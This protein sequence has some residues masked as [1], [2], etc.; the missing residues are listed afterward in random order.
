M[1]KSSRRVLLGGGWNW[2]QNKHIA[3]TIS[4]TR[5]RELIYIAELLLQPDELQDGPAKPKRKRTDG[6][7]VPVNNIVVDSGHTSRI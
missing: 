1:E 4:D 6:I 5:R 7:I 3:L 2:Q